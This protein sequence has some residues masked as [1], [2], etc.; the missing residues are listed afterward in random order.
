MRQRFA[1]TLSAGGRWP[2][3]DSGRNLP[4]FNWV[5]IDNRGSN[6]VDVALSGNPAAAD[7]VDTIMTVG[8]GKVRVFNV[9]GPA[10]P[11]ADAPDG[12]EAWPQELHLVSAAGTSLVV[13]IADHPIVD[14]VL[15]T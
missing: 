15:A 13:E 11:R 1:F 4:P 2:E 5:K 12:G 3:A 14:L 8:S 9:A 6:A 7:K 10:P